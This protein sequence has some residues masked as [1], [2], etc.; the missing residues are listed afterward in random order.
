MTNNIINKHTFHDEDVPLICPV[1]T[2][3]SPTIFH[4][5]VFHGEVAAMATAGSAQSIQIERWRAELQRQP[6]VATAVRG[7]AGEGDL[8]PLP[9]Y[10]CCCTGISVWVWGWGWRWWVVG[11]GTYVIRWGKGGGG[12][13]KEE[14]EGSRQAL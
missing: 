5:D 10:Q 6:R 9:Y 2:D 12:G 4:S 3:V 14:R 7:T 11:D 13:I 1:N 8:L